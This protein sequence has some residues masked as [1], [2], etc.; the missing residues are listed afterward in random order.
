V[1][2]AV[3]EFDSNEVLGPAGSGKTTVVVDRYHKIG[4]NTYTCKSSPCSG[5]HI[6]LGLGYGGS[7]T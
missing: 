3:M 2:C 1:P 7:V 5:S 6:W 4:G